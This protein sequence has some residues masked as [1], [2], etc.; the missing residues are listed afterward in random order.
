MLILV[1]MLRCWKLTRRYCFFEAKRKPCVWRESRFM[2][3]TN[4]L[5]NFLRRLVSAILASRLVFAA[6]HVG[7]HYG[8][9]WTV[10]I[11]A[12]PSPHTRNENAASAG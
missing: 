10:G 1:H 12:L 8:V 9:R 5:M 6:L 11:V 3:R 2:F 7:T 4:N